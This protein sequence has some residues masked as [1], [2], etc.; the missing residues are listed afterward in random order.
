MFPIELVG[1]KT[2][3]TKSAR[4]PGVIF[5]TNLTFSGMS[6]Q[7]AA[8][9][10]ISQQCAAHGGI[11]QQCAAHGG[12]SQQCAAH[13]GISQQCA[14]HGGMSQQCAAHVLP[15]EGYAVYSSLP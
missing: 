10:G 13:G 4:N 1:V 9:G 7:C 6:Q 2:N 14:A 12:M 8:H 5:H 15:C 3:P 11:S